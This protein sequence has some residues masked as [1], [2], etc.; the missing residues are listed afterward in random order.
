MK[1][2]FNF[3]IIRQKTGHADGSKSKKTFKVLRGTFT[4]EQMKKET[5]RCLECGDAVVDEYM[6][7]GCGQ[8][9]T[10]FKFDAIPLVR[11]YDSAGVPLKEMKQTIVKVNLSSIS[12]TKEN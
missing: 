2:D 11:K 3:S 5:E 6:C 1:L 12:G 4:E 10:K 9:T 7:I 8:C